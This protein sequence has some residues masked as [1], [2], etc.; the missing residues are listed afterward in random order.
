MS[1]VQTSF[2]HALFGLATAVIATA[3]AQP[4]FAGERMSDARFI[5]AARCAAWEPVARPDAGIAALYAAQP[6]RLPTVQDRARLAW[7][8]AD[9]SARRAARGDELAVTQLRIRFDRE[10]AAFLPAAPQL[11]RGQ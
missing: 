11:A 3:P 4:V 2:L 1:L 8:E 6:R 5:A 10:C 9:R 7:V